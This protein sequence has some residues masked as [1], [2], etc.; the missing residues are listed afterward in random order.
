MITFASVNRCQIYYKHYC[1]LYE[2]PCSFHI[3][4]IYSYIVL[5]MGRSKGQSVLYFP[6]SSK[7]AVWKI[8]YS[9]EEYVINLL[10]FL[11]DSKFQKVKIAFLHNSIYSQHNDRLKDVT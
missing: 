6:L 10:L 3:M 8:K 5:C 9:Y 7:G 11:L 1:M 4:L 2:L